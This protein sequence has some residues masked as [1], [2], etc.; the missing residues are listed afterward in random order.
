VDNSLN[1][2]L[3]ECEVKKNPA[4]FHCWSHKSNI[5]QPSIRVGGHHGGTIRYTVGIIEYEDGTVHECYP[6]EI[7]FTDYMVGIDLA[8]NKDKTLINGEEVIE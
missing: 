3:R 7:R 2:K 8:K 6:D 4:K 5:I 1:I